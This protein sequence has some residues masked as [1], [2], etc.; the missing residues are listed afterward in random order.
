[1]I[2]QENHNSS[3]EAIHSLIIQIK[4]MTVNNKPHLE[5][6]HFI[7][8]IEYL[9]QLIVSDEDQTALFDEQLEKICQKY[10]LFAIFNKY[11]NGG[12]VSG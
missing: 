8:D 11:K 10:N 7:D 12:N 4:L 3:I 1:M 5:M 6:Y 2:R 9:P